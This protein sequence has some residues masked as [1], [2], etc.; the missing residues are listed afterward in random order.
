M[1]FSAGPNCSDVCQRYKN[2]MCYCCICCVVVFLL[3]YCF[4]IVVL[5]FVVVLLLCVC[6]DGCS[7]IQLCADLLS[8]RPDPH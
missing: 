1:F 4:I 2:L 8:E 5:L 6:D 7:V 3:C